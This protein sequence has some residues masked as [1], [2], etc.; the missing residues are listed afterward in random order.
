[1][2]QLNSIE[3]EYR[4]LHEKDLVEVSNLIRSMA[5]KPEDGY[6]LRS[7]A[8]D[9]Y[10][11]IY[12]KNPA[13]KAI[14]WGA[15]HKGKIVASFAIA[16][17]RFY[18]EGREVII[19]KTMDMFTHPAYQGMG[20]M[21]KLVGYVSQQAREQGITTWY[22]T[23]SKNSY[24][25]FIHKWMYEEKFELLYIAR[26]IK[27][28]NVLKSMKV[29]PLL[30]LSAGL[31]ADAAFFIRDN[32][33]AE[34]RHAFDVKHI[35]RFGSEM[36]RLWAMC[37]KEKVILKRDALYMNWRYADNPDDYIMRAFYKGETLIG[38]LVLKTVTRKFLKVG[39]FMDMVFYSD[40]AASEMI[41]Y[42]ISY[43]INEKCDVVQ[44]WV[45]ENSALH[46][47]YVRNGI[48]RNRKKLKCVLS[49]ES[50]YRSIY[51]KDAWYFT[52]GDGNDL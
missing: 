34:K 32:L 24:P 33:F 46:A 7:T 14:V 51:E 19:G 2:L 52:Q 8:A 15:L 39:E 21:K 31:V 45:I 38:I 49:P 41:R 27:P 9:Y 35:S 5:V 25:I 26:I 44:T 11:W 22:V 29:N 13:G 6:W 17:K 37:K 23:P 28:G 1:M 47:L 48:S 42:G 12:I 43:L 16:P 20:L 40:E 50:S 10:D 3:I 36:D 30:R 18:I 4:Q